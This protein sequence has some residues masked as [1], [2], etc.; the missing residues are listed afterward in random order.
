MLRHTCFFLCAF[1]ATS[2][3]AQNKDITDLKKI[4]EDWLHSYITRDPAT[5]N[6]I[7]ADDFILINP[8]GAKWRK[9]DVINNLSKQETVSVNAD[10]VDVRLLNDNTA[11][12]TAYCSMVLKV[13]GK[14]VHA[15]NCYQDVYLKRKNEWQVV[16][17]HVTLLE[18]AGK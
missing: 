14:D 1:L 2:T 4:N 9:A 5:M 12:I 15:K 3:F 10:S 13:D 7:F 17:A 18:F 16:A 11:I 6:K 8:K